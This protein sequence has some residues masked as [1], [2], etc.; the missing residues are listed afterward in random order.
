MNVNIDMTC[1]DILHHINDDLKIQY[2]LFPSE[3]YLLI[4]KK[5]FSNKS[6][7]I[8]LVV[9]NCNVINIDL[10]IKLMGGISIDLNSRP[11]SCNFVVFIS[12][13]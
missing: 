12:V 2:G 8:R 5:Y 4:N 10:I 11:V 7:T 3:Y 13:Q 9:D 6:H 1:S